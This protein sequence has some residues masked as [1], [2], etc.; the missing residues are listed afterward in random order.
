V[1]SDEAR[2]LY[3]WLTIRRCAEQIDMCTEYIR[4]EIKAGR[5]P[6]SKFGS[7]WRITPDDWQAWLREHKHEVRAA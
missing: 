3:T 7:V 2:A 5:L 4:L 1:K 6:A